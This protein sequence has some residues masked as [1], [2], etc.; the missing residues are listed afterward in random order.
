MKQLTLCFLVKSNKVLLGMKK[1]GHG[2]GKWN[3]FGGK[4]QDGEEVLNAAIR[5]TKE[6]INVIPK[7]LKKV[8]EAF[9]FPYNLQ[10]T[11]FIVSDWEGNP[12]ESEEMAPK[13]FPKRKLP[14]EMWETDTLWLPRILA[15]EE[16]TM[17]FLDD[18]NGKIIDQK[19]VK[20]HF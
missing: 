11:I 3:G 17:E 2:E 15:G 9:Y 12:E 20:S 16:L 8:A 19:I 10:M 6:E 4:V 1:R 7:N 5:E 14:K 13:W 18:G